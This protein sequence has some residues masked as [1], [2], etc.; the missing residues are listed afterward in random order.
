MPTTSFECTMLD[1][2]APKW[3]HYGYPN[4][5]RP[6]RELGSPSARSIA[7]LEGLFSVPGVR[8]S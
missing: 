4:A 8:P 6:A 2:D 1:K 7:Q 3:E 5:G